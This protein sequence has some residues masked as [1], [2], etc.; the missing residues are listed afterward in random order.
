MNEHHN[1]AFQRGFR[2]PLALLGI[3]PGN[4]F[5]SVGTHRLCVRFGPWTVTTALANIEDVAVTGPYSAIKAVGVR[6]SAADRGLTFG[7][8]T[9]P[10]VCVRFRE[11]VPGIE[12]VGVLRHSALTVTVRLP[13][14]LADLLRSRIARS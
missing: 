11:P 1:F 2:L 5:V 7:T 3:R 6:L 14:E 10:G 8:G 13:H 9:G 12:P 4:S